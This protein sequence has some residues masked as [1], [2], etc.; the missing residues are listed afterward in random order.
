MTNIELHLFTNST[1]NS[2]S[3]TIIEQT[4]LSFE[5]IFKIK[6]NTTVWCDP[7]PNLEKSEEYIFKLKKLFSNVITTNSLIDGYTRAIETSNQDYL[8]MLEHDWLI[9][10][11]LKNSLDEIIEDMEQNHLWYLL[12]NKFNNFDNTP[13]NPLSEIKSGKFINY[14]FMNRFSNNPHII[15]RN[16]YKKNAY[17]YINKTENGAGGI[18]WELTKSPLKGA[19]YGDLML[20]A[21]IKH[22]NGR[23]AR[24]AT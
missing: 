13:H 11:T 5:K 12:F 4:V 17:S 22:L 20:P 15:N 14:Y 6:L 1:V 10:P 2:P 9:L 3:T 21:T 18:E 19:V 24:D 16:E 7:T 8:F 23:G